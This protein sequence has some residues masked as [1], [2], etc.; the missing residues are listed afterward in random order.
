MTS[1]ARTKSND[2]HQRSLFDEPAA[3]TVDAPVETTV[4]ATVAATTDDATEPRVAGPLQGRVE[5]QFDALPAAWKALTAPFVASDAYGPLCRFVDA[6][7]AAGKTVYPADIF[8]ALRMTSPH[9][10]KV[11][12]LGQDPY[13]GDDHGIAQAHGMAFSV[14]RGV[15]VPPSLRNIYKEIERDLGVSPPSHGN[16]DAWAKQGVLLLNTTLTVEAGNAASHAKPFKKGGWQACTDSLLG[17]LAAQQG[18]L[19]FLLWGS[20]AQAKAPLLSGHGHLLLEAPHPSPL[21]AHRGF[22]GCGH[23]S[24]ANAFLEQHGKMP[25]DWRVVD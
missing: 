7:V 20:H 1:R 2:T 3:G 4:T 18:P 5:A 14:Q 21:S 8:H 11:V 25:I 22:L 15:R 23:F 6:E 12:I 17:G 19:V 16:L 10:V 9:D 13:H 24:A